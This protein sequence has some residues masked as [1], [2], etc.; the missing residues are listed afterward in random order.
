MANNQ[1]SSNQ[2]ASNRNASDR[3]ASNRNASNRNASNKNA[4]NKNASNRNASNRNA[5]RLQF[6]RQKWYELQR[7]IVRCERNRCV[8]HTGSYAVRG[9]WIWNKW[10]NKRP[11]FLTSMLCY[12]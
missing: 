4:S 6:V 3:N 8:K 9:N 5:F 12:K 7:Q 2:N 1:N 10:E 11:A